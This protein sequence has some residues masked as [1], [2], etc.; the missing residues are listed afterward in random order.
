[1]A[2]QV[3][4]KRLHEWL[5]ENCHLTW[6]H[7]SETY[8]EGAFGSKNKEATIAIKY[9]FPTIDTR[10]MTIY[11]VTTDCLSRYAADFREDFDGDILDLLKHKILNEDSVPEGIDE[12]QRIRQIQIERFNKEFPDVANT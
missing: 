11:N 2:K 3:T 10:T 12:Y 8:G 6:H 7:G 1:M 9:L 5:K 4:I